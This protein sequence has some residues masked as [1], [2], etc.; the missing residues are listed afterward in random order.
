M[1]KENQD[2]SI[3]DFDSAFKEELAERVAEFENPD[4]DY[5]TTFNKKDA[6]AAIT[7]IA[8]SFV[9]MIAVYVL[10]GV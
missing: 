4:Y 10:W 1:P 8:I 6:F 5:G 3:A 9:A 2:G 7:I